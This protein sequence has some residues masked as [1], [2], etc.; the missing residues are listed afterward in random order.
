M[1]A[2]WQKLRA[3]ELIT[4][5]VD[6]EWVVATC[7]LLGNAETYVHMTRT[8]RWTP[9]EYEHWRYRTWRYLAT[10]HAS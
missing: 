10:S 9:E 5:D 8:L 7:A 3:D 1:R 4:P 6:L 2:F